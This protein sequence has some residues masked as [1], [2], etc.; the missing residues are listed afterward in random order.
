MAEIA[1]SCRTER[2]RFERD[3]KKREKELE[4]DLN[5]L[6]KINQMAIE[7][8]EKV[9][10]WKK[11]VLS[12]KREIYRKYEVNFEEYQEWKKQLRSKVEGDRK[13]LKRITGECVEVVSKT[14]LDHETFLKEFS[15][16]ARPRESSAQDMDTE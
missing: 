2:A 9:C 7:H 8:K 11:A 13:E 5:A 14:I 3:K 1:E 4:D 15:E 16:D 6:I 10:E 12:E